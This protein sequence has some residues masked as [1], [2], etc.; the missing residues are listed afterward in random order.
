M[1]ENNVYIISLFVGGSDFR[2]FTTIKFNIKNIANKFMIVNSENSNTKRIAIDRLLEVESDIKE[3][4][5]KMIQYKVVCKEEDIKKAKQL[6]IDKMQEQVIRR[7]ESI[8][9]I[10][11]NFNLIKGNFYEE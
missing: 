8:E 10:E 11:N 1:E 5:Y 2:D 3:D 7:K 6:I 4:I 9:N